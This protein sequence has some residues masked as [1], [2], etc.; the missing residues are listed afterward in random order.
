MTLLR[1]FKRFFDLSP[2]MLCI[3]QTDGYFKRLNPA[4]HRTLGWT[5]DEL[6]DK[7]FYE[8][9]HPDDVDTTT[10]EIEKLAQ[11]IPT[12]SFENRFRCADAT[13]R[14][15]LWTSHPEPETGLLYAIARDITDQPELGRPPAV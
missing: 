4:F 14:R 12:I 3:A 2:D 13:Y 9:I 10:R 5:L 6:L 7:P 1:E 11:G 15:F 8:F